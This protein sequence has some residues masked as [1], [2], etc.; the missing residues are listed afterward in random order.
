MALQ[1][2]ITGAEYG[3]ALVRALKS[4]ALLRESWIGMI[5]AAIIIFWS[6]VALSAPWLAPLDPNAVIQA[7]AKPGAAGPDGVTFWLGTDHLGRDI[8][9]RLMW[10]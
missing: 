3:G 8:L 2:T 5:G 4:F 6:L 10:G 7:F 1:T 9:S